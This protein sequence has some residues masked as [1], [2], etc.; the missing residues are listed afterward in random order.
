MKIYIQTDVEHYGMPRFLI[1]YI[2]KLGIREKNDENPDVVFNIDSI[3]IKGI[4]KGKK[5]TVYLSGDEYLTKGSQPNRYAQS[6]ILYILQKNYLRYYP[7]KAKVLWMGI[8]PEWHYPRDVKKEYD[9]VFVGR[10]RGCDVYDHRAS[11]LE[12]LKKSKYKVLV[13]EGTPET[14]CDLCC[15]GRI[16][17]D[18]LPRRG[19]DVC[20]NI[21]VLE[22]MAMGCMMTDYDKSLDDWG[23]IP[24]VHYL[25]LD[26]FG[27]ISDEEINRIH[28]TG[29]EYVLKNFSFVDTVN[30]IVKD[31]EEFIHER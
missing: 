31:I 29:R 11:V 8:D 22:G 18:V 10:T 26:R 7:S 17:L 5:C 27:D 20:A 3:D 16:I 6:D 4:K 9:Y 1:K 24:N 23:I 28:K 12:E 21:R 2:E 30:R 13:T 14:Y 25:T 15:S 19:N